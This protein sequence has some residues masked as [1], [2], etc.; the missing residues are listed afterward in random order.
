MMNRPC[1]TI[2][3]VEGDARFNGMVMVRD[4]LL[5]RSR[6]GACAFF[7]STTH[8]NGGATMRILFSVL[9]FLILVQT[10]VSVRAEPQDFTVTAVMKGSTTISGQKIE[11]PKTD[12]AEMASVLVEIQPGKENGR[13]MH[14]VPTYVHV[15]EGTMTVEFEDGARQTFHAGSGFLEV[16]N[17]VHSAKNLGEVPLRLLVVFVG[18]EGKPNLIRPEKHQASDATR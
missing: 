16:V 12:K 2:P 4:V 17:T 15:L 14:A 13:H 9:F 8:A 1:G 5:S 11:Y 3:V 18:E 10:T 7:G 6:C